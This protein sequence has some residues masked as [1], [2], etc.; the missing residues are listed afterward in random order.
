MFPENVIVF[1]LEGLSLKIVLHHGK[2]HGK[3]YFHVSLNCFIQQLRI[4]GGYK[5]SLNLNLNM[6]SFKSPV[7][8][9]F[10]KTMFCMF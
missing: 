10:C 1:S 6:L 4:R 7:N 3:F 5:M 8:A 2:P 9:L